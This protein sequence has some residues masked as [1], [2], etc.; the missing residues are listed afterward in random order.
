MEPADQEEYPLAYDLTAMQNVKYHNSA[1][2]YI[3]DLEFTL[4]ILIEKCKNFDCK[5]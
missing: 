4:E 5:M 2:L 1:L 3:L